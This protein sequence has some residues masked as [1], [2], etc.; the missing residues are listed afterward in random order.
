MKEDECGFPLLVGVMPDPSRAELVV[1]DGQLNV[2]DVK[3]WG[4]GHG[5][6]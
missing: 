4:I 2:F 1:P 6:F 3:R 5:E